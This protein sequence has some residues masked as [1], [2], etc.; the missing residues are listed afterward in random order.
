MSAQEEIGEHIHHASD[1]FEKLVA[2]NMAV[3]A[4]FLAIV[5]VLGQHYNTEELLKQQ[6]SSDQWAY[7]QAKNIRLY[8]AQSTQD[9][10]TAGKFEKETIARYQADSARYK[11]DD[12]A[13]QEKARDLERERDASGRKA[14]EFHIGEVFLEVAIVLL[15][16][17]ILTRRRPLAFA[18]IASTTVG[19][20]WAIHAFLR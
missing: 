5:S 9:L 13:I 11:Q 17:T 2:G 14:R 15:S 20:V 19:L 6:E 3:V 16:L 8:I 4:A 1:R 12:S 7:Y 10:M 18:G